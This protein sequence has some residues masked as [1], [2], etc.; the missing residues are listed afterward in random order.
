MKATGASWSDCAS[1]TLDGQPDF[2]HKA[3]ESH[4]CNGATA[5]KIRPS[6]SHHS[7]SCIVDSSSPTCSKMVGSQRPQPQ[8]Q[9]EQHR[10]W[11]R[12]QVQKNKRQDKDTEKDE[13]SRSDSLNMAAQK[14][15]T[16]DSSHRHRISNSGNA[17]GFNGRTTEWE[18][19][20]TTVVIQNL[21]PYCRKNKIDAELHQLGYEG[22]YDHIHVP[23]AMFQPG[24]KRAVAFVNFTSEEA[25]LR[26]AKGF[27]NKELFCGNR[28]RVAPAK[29][30]GNS[31]NVERWKGRAIQ[32]VRKTES[33]LMQQCRV[34]GGGG[35][36]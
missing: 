14:D 10:Q 13:F 22:Q 29:T 35:Q 31:A 24:R 28:V 4:S 6:G 20:A 34:A 3:C 2:S 15:T 32:H 16:C 8:L 27:D 9:R 30:Q 19:G 21:Q 12:R 5:A 25:C 18:S 11:R 36:N 17:C 1:D 7:G 33:P 23:P 26:F